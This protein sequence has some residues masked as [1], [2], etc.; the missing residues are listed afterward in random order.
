M[1]KKEARKKTRELIRRSA[2]RMRKNIEKVFLSGAVNLPAYEDNYVLPTAIML[3]LLKEEM[4]EFQ[5]S[6]FSRYKKQIEKD[7]KNIYA[8][9]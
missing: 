2:D 6:Q 3:A 4:R 8:N 7:A 9:I 1:T 5:P